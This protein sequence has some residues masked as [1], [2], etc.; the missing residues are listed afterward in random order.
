MAR[1]MRGLSI[2][3]LFVCVFEKSCTFGMLIISFGCQR[4]EMPEEE[5]YSAELIK[6]MMKAFF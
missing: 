6:F 2:P 3:L 4:S 5:L 1:E